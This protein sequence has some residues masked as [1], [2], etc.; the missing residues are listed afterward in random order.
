MIAQVVHVDLHILHCLATHIVEGACYEGA[1]LLAILVGDAGMLAPVSQA[2]AC[3]YIVWTFTYLT[4][5][6]AA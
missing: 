6:A 1:E 4:W 2:I 5:T 3:M